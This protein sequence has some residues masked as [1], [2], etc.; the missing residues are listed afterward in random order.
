MSNITEDHS[1]AATKIHTYLAQYLHIFLS[2][3]HLLFN[4]T[5]YIFFFENLLPVNEC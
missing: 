4:I 3:S 5:L 1:S 2:F